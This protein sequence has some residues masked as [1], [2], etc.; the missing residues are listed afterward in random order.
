MVLLNEM[1]QTGIFILWILCIRKE[2]NWCFRLKGG[3]WEVADWSKEDKQLLVSEG[4]SVNE[5]HLWL[6][7]VA[8]GNKTALTQQGE[9]NVAYNN[10][11]FSKD[12]RGIY[13]TTDQD[14]EFQRLAYMDLAGQNLICM[15]IINRRIKTI[16]ANLIIV[17]YK[18]LLP[19]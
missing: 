5:S 19:A 10:N 4:I 12:R 14:N 2:I 9:K 6:V 1:V 8:T 17:V 13:F 18:K 7:D 16:S 3:R 11:F 15:Q